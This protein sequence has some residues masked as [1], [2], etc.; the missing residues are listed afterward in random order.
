MTIITALMM[1]VTLIPSF[2]YAS[3]PDENSF[4]LPT[5]TEANEDTA[6]QLDDTTD[7]DVWYET[8]KGL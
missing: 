6:T 5:E 7:F 3:E 1:A 4:N 2:T 8:P